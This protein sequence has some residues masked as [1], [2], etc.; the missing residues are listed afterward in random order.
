MVA[1]LKRE[2]PGERRLLVLWIKVKLAG[3]SKEFM[4]FFHP[5]LEL[6][7]SS[8]KPQTINRTATKEAA[9]TT[10]SLRKESKPF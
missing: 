1:H 3:E 9:H 6:Y 4:S 8:P 10:K 5:D 2:R 7:S